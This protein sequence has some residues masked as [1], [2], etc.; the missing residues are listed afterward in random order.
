MCVKYIGTTSA[1]INVTSIRPTCAHQIS[2]SSSLRYTISLDYFHNSTLFSPR[3]TFFGA[4]CSSPDGDER[5]SVVMA[6]CCTGYTLGAYRHCNWISCEYVCHTFYVIATVITLRYHLHSAYPMQPHSSAD[7]TRRNNT[8]DYKIPRWS[9][10]FYVAISGLNSVE[11]N[12]ML[13]CG[14]IWT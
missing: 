11:F 13:F 3:C 5:V 4:G 6:T 9:I 2:R 12:K 14:W 7:L 1:V 8:E 10:G